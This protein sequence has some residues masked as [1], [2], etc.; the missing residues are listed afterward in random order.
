MGRTRWQSL[1]IR[2]DARSIASSRRSAIL[3]LQLPPRRRYPPRGRRTMACW[4]SWMSTAR[5]APA[6][7]TPARAHHQFE[8]LSARRS[9]LRRSKLWRIARMIRRSV[10]EEP[11]RHARAAPKA[12]AAARLRGPSLCAL[13]PSRLLRTWRIGWCVPVQILRLPLRASP[14]NPHSCLPKALARAIRQRHPL[15]R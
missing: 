9:C 13:T 5:C 8:N 3:R 2:S 7:A 12:Q 11:A 4:P 6:G 14:S 1:R 10:R 15:T